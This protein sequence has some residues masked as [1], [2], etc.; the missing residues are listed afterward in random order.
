MRRPVAMMGEPMNAF[1]WLQHIDNGILV[2]YN[3]LGKYRRRMR[4]PRGA[5]FMGMQIPE[6]GEDEGAMAETYFVMQRTVF[7]STLQEVYK[8]VED[9]TKANQEVEKLEKEGKL[10]GGTFVTEA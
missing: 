1:C 5:A 10:M 6:E 3:V 4:M 8:A 9:A 2:H 7:C